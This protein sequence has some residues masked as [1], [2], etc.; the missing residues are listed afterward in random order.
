MIAP[1]N[2]NITVNISS[3]PNNIKKVA[4]NLAISGRLFQLDDGPICPNP[5]PILPIAD[6]EID[7]ELIKSDPK[8]AKIV[9]AKTKITI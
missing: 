3:L 5:G 4:N 9:A 6:A 2:N 8:K 7:R 1:D